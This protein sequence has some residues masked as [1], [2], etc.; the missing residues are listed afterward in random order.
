[1]KPLIVA[2]DVESDK[3]A[4]TLIKATK[5]YVDLYKIG[6]GLILRYGPKIIQKIRKQKK[7]SLKNRPR[8]SQK[9]RRLIPRQKARV[10]FQM[11]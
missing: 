6:P 1:M 11:I 7:R 5:K 2:L 9:I 10:L 4:L 8:Q 3:E